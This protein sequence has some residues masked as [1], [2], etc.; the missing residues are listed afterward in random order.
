M[1]YIINNKLNVYCFLQL[2]YGDLVKE[3]QLYLHTKY[4]STL[5]F[6]QLS[7]VRFLKCE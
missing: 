7:K 1:L 5:T 4:T 3:E 2:F 6:F